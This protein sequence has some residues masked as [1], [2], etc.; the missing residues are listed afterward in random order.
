[1][2]P[3]SDGDRVSDNLII[4]ANANTIVNN[5][6]YNAPDKGVRFHAS[7]W[8][9]TLR[10]NIIWSNDRG[11]IGYTSGATAGAQAALTN[12][13]TTNPLFVDAASADFYL[14]EGSGAIDAGTFLNAPLFDIVGNSRPV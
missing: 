3:L 4:G 1:M 2:T 5:T 11:E 8:N 6:I 13:L 12:N 14:R 9:N 10:N 7:A